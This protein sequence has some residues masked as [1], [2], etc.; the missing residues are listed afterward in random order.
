MPAPTIGDISAQAGSTSI[1]AFAHIV[2]TG[3]RLL[4]YVSIRSTTGE[5]VASITWNGTENLT[6]VHQRIS[7][8]FVA[9]I[10]HLA[11]PTPGTFNVVVT[12]TGTAQ[13]A[14]AGAISVAGMP[15]NPTLF[16]GN[17]LT[18]AAP[19]VTTSGVPANSLVVGS[20][21]V[22]HTVDE[23]LVPVSPAIE[24]WEVGNTGRSQ[25]GARQ[26]G[27]GTVVMGWTYTTSAFAILVTAALTG[28]SDSLAPPL[29]AAV[30][31][32]RPSRGRRR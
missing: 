26:G 30:V 32:Y 4:V 24:L 21:F 8:N 22:N 17:D 3:E 14:A 20:C 13:Q 12:L 25:A 10:W 6:Q 11:N 9:E 2:A 29:P 15:S 7:A 19:T 16:S 18:S 31:W 28:A 27:T 1:P 5:Q 23:D